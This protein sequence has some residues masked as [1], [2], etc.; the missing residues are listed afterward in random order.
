MDPQVK[1]A[2][3]G[4]VTTAATLGLFYLLG[5]S[6]SNGNKQT[7]TPHKP[8]ATQSSQHI[9][10]RIEHTQEDGEYC[11]LLGDVGG[12]NV[13]LVLKNVYLNDKDRSEVIKED[14]I[15]S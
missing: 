1:G 14:S 7:H 3:L 4:G 8:P 12:T 13:R 10:K 15:D 5:K 6:L 2:V 9:R 11:V